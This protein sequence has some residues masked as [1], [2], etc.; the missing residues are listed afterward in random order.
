MNEVA[1]YTDAK[2]LS[3]ISLWYAVIAAIICALAFGTSNLLVL[4]IFALILA[5]AAVFGVV[6]N[7]KEISAHRLLFKADDKGVTDYSKPNDVLFMPWERIE[8]ID[9]KAA[10]NENLMLD[11]IAYKTTDELK[12]LSDEQREQLNDAGGKAYILLECSGLWVSRSIILNA[13]EEISV[14][15]A[16]YNPEVVCTG[17]QD[18]LAQKSKAGRE[19]LER[20]RKRHDQAVRE[21]AAAQE[22]VATEQK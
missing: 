22:N 3:L 10:N 7:I 2:K 20:R 9:L 12:G 8:R 19:R 21:R 5:A 4:R 1:I 14:L 13:F 16:R 15:A 11:V 6:H 18:P 17:Y